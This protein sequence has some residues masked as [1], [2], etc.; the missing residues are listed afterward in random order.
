MDEH[1]RSPLTAVRG[2]QFHYVIFSP[3]CQTNVDTHTYTPENNT[4]GKGT[5]AEQQGRPHIPVKYLF[6]GLTHSHIVVHINHLC[7]Y[8]HVDD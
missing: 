2:E 7:I 3:G 8:A 1:A 4:K 6:H 5:H